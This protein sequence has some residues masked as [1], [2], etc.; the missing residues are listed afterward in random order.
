MTRQRLLAALIILI[1]AIAGIRLA[2][3]WLQPTSQLQ[4]LAGPPRSGYT[5]KDFTYRQYNASGKLDMRLSG[6][7]M[8]RREQ[9]KSFYLES[10]RFRIASDTKGRGK[11]WTGHSAHGWL[12]SDYSVLKLLGPAHMHRATFADVPE[13]TLDSTDITV[14]TDAK[15]MATDNHARVRQGTSRMSGDG[16]RARLNSHYL[17]LQNDFHGTFEPA[18]HD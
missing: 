15:R 14:W 5:L 6:P 10:P 1:L 7:S 9:D 13:T 2:M 17:E 11:P 18:S 3:W 4:S 12:S 16:M 8:A